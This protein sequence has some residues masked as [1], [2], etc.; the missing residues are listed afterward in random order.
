MTYIWDK[1]KRS[2]IAYSLFECLTNFIYLLVGAGGGIGRAVCLE[3]AREGARIAAVDI[4]DE[5]TEET[6]KQCGIIKTFILINKTSSFTKHFVRSY[7][8]KCSAHPHRAPLIYL[9]VNSQLLLF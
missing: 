3:F 5:N 4:H 6:I 8:F 2:R 1:Y 9:D 7:Y